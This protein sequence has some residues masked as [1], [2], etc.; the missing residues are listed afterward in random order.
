MC[1]SQIRAPDPARVAYVCFKSARHNAI[2]WKNPY[3]QFMKQE[4]LFAVALLAAGCLLCFSQLSGPAKST[5][6]I[7]SSLE[8]T[9]ASNQSVANGMHERV[10]T[11]QRFDAGNNGQPGTNRNLKVAVQASY[12]ETAELDQE[13]TH[14]TLPTGTRSSLTPELFVHQESSPEAISFLAEI[15]KQVSNSQP[16]GSS[17]ELTGN[18]FGQVVSASGDYYQLGRQI[19]DYQK[20]LWYCTKILGQKSLAQHRDLRETPGAHSADCQR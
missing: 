7:P 9:T 1:R 5:S 16:I 12:Q 15:S 14:Q 17:I 10:E 19:A 8:Q 2:L 20:E 3:I 11:G 4:L 18:L 13:Q 6:K